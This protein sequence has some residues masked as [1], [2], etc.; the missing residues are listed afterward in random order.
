[1][2]KKREHGG[3]S[4]S[5][6]HIYLSQDSHQELYAFIKSS[7]SASNLLLYFTLSKVTLFIEADGNKSSS[8]PYY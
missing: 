8:I 4:W 2:Y 5:R 6:S 7:G 1:M 3:F